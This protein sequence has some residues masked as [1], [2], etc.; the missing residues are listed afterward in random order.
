MARVSARVKRAEIAGGLGA[1]ALGVG[2]GAAGASLVGRAWPVVVLAGLISHAWG[3]WDKHRTEAGSLG[4]PGWANAL[5]RVCW[6]SLM[7]VAAY[8]LLRLV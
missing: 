7:L 2:I 3:M 4:L 5:Y 1:L 6:V 8:L